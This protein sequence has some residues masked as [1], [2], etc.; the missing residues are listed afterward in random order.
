[1]LLVRLSGHSGAGKSRLLAELPKKGINYK[2]VII[3]TSRSP[4]V[5]EIDGKDYFFQSK[6]FINHLPSD[7]FLKA[8]IHGMIQAIDLNKLEEDLLLNKIVI[9]EIHSKR[10]TEL[11][12]VITHSFKIKP[13]IVSVF[14]NAVDPS[15]FLQKSYTKAA[16]IIEKRVRDILEMRGKNTIKDIRIRAK[17][18]SK[19]V[20]E[21]YGWKRDLKN[22]KSATIKM[23]DYNEIILS[24]PE[25]P[26][27]KDDWTRK[28]YP[29]G[30]AAH[31][32]R[33][34]ISIIKKASVDRL[35]EI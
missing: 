10:W 17:S 4:R 13:K 15:T 2:K 34:F 35:K 14:L 1:M 25:G 11:K 28:K 12:N 3:Y 8:T 20:L 18:A 24:S 30:Q 19:E 23:S 16:Q 9:M 27:G 22:R 5:G 7:V 32:L 26:D 33:E 6:K 21:A 29:V 31:A